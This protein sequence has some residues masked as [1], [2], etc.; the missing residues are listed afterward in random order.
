MLHYLTDRI[1]S[2]LY[3]FIKTIS[4]R[5]NPDESILV[6]AQEADRKGI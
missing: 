3:I 1:Y 5:S 6:S 2:S 4:D